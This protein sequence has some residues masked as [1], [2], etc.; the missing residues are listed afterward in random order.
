VTKPIRTSP[1]LKANDKII[2]GRFGA[3]FG[4]KGWVKVLSYTDPITNLLEYRPWYIQ[5]GNEW[6]IFQIEDGKVHGHQL[7]VK[8]SH[9]D[10]RSQ[11]ETYTHLEI[12]ISADTLPKLKENE[13]YWSDLIGLTVINLQMT[14]GANDILV[15]SGDKERLIPYLKHVIIKVDLTA[16]RILVDWDS[17]F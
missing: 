15:V 16:K 2:M 13:Y 4:I 9:C 11:A 14:T 10:D 5:Q 6:K 1:H 7:I 17:T 12:A 8:P 3:A